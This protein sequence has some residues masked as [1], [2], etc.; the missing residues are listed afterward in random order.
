MDDA[1]TLKV[2]IQKRRNTGG[3]KK[4]TIIRFA[5]KGGEEDIIDQCKDGQ[6][7]NLWPRTVSYRYHVY[8]PGNPD[9]GGK[10]STVPDKYTEAI[11]VAKEENCLIG[12][13]IYVING[14]KKVKI[15]LYSKNASDSERGEQTKIFA[16]RLSKKYRP[17]N[18]SYVKYFYV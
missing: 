8:R 15:E 18:P 14:K 7:L 17:Q 4:N 9:V 10:V 5:P 2:T 12:A 3:V 13:E 6:P 16:E 1:K 11:S